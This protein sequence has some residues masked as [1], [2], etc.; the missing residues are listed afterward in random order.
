MV[1]KMKYK[2]KRK[3]FVYFIFIL[4]LT[5]FSSIYALLIF[6]N[7]ANSH[8]SS[9][10]TITFIMGVI[11][12][13]VLGFLAGNSARKNGLLEGLTA[14]LF[15]ILVA[16]IINFFV[17]VPFVTRSFV[18]TVSYLTSAALGGIVGVNFRPL[19]KQN[20]GE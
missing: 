5:I 15:I 16:L 13:L 10:N 14:A 9:F 17:H 4:I 3:I 20:E 18:K 12:F 2:I 6:L 7:K 8:L 11:A 19:F 1:I